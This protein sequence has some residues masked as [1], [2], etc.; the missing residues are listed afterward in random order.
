MRTV[1]VGL[2]LLLFRSGVFSLME[3]S[4]N[5]DIRN[6]VVGNGKVFVVTDSQLLQMKHDLVVE[7]HKGISNHTHPNRLT[8][9]L[10]FDMNKTLISC[11][12]SD[13]GYCEVLDLDDLSRSIYRKGV[14]AG[15]SVEESSVAFLVDFHERNSE[16]GA[17]ILVARENEDQVKKKAV[18]KDC[19]S[20]DDGGVTLRNTLDSQTGGIFSKSQASA[21][22]NISP[23]GDVEWVDGFQTSSPSHSYLLVNV[24]PEADAAVMVLRME[25][26]HIKSDMTKSLKG[27]ELQC[28]DDKPHRKLLSSAV[29]SSGS[30]LLWVGVFTAQA[31]L[32]NTVLAIYDFSQIRSQ[33]PSQF[34]CS[35]ACTP[36]GGNAVL[37]PRAVVLRH[38]SMTSVAAEKKGSWIVIYIG[39]NNGQLMK[40]VLDKNFRSGCV[41]VLYRSDDD[42]MVFPR[43][44]FDPV[45]NQY[46]YIALRNQIRR[47]AVTQ[48]GTYST[49]RDCRSSPDPL[50]GWCVTTSKC[51]TNAE[52]SSSSWISIPEDSFQKKLITFLISEVSTEVTLNLHLNVEGTHNP[53]FT[54]TFKA[55]AEDLC[56]PNAVFP[57]CSCS[58]LSQR[59]PANVTAT[60]TIGNQ[61]ITENLKLRSCPDITETSPYAKCVACVSAG[62]HWFSS[63]QECSWT[64]GSVD[65]LTFN[66]AC[67]GLSSGEN[68][69]EILSLEPNEVSFHGR[70][71]AVMKGKNLRLVENIRFQGFAECTTKE[72]PVTERSSDTLKFNIPS[73]NKGSTRVCVVTADGH[74]HSNT[75]ITYGSQPTCTGLQPSV[76][77]ASGGRKIQLRGD[78]LKYVDTV[79]V[80]PKVIT[81]VFFLNKTFWFHTHG[82]REYKDSFNVS[83]RVG[84][85]TVDCV[86]KLSYLPDPEFITFSTFGTGVIQVT[87]QKK[88]D[89]LSISIADVK[90]WGLSG[91]KLHE[92]KIKEITPT[93][94]ICTIL[95]EK[96]DVINVDSIKVEVGEF[97]TAVYVNGSNYIYI[98]VTLIILI[99]LGSLGM[100][101]MHIFGFVGQVFDSDVG[102]YR[103]PVKKMQQRSYMARN[104]EDKSSCR[105]LDQARIGRPAR[106]EWL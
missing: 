21:S 41:T 92:C 14:S 57:S 60:V 78:N 6:F 73:G 32:E 58:F 37:A 89:M 82:L 85:T 22:A 96:E 66:D 51:S 69:P 43:M 17:Y 31:E 79:I 36:E 55:G 100:E 46:I 62:C 88:T 61:T 56:S 11:G 44:L 15:P 16:N 42:R 98:L 26:S 7:K 27:A 47:V 45:D 24:N 20:L 65:S 40:M 23:Q 18:Q 103:K 71:N 49:L 9:L 34:T 30:P 72:T 91:E 50:C 105:I 10:P 2:L 97:K 67:Q 95:G 63:S 54:C 81:P 4:V 86:D 68:V 29:I 48:C 70:N 13:C 87:I 84:N 93:A 101:D 99:L 102:R 12:T 19:G 8:L 52:C 64:H 76:T 75:I 74:C 39:T 80:S 90:V 83:L 35:P 25:N 94:V 104:I 28:C 59:L 1:L 5:G 77:W 38:S 53:T 3:Q 106:M 33:V